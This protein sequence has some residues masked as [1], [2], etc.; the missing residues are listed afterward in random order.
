MSARK[1]SKKDVESDEEVFEV[2]DIVAHREQGVRAFIVLRAARRIPLKINFERRNASA[3][4][5]SGA[6]T[7]TSTTR[8]RTPKTCSARS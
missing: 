7:A 2:E 6:G 5:S 3:T 4:A 8:G 1:D